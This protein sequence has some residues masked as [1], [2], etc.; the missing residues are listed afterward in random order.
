VP[1][2]FQRANTSAGD[3]AIEAFTCVLIFK[4]SLFSLIARLLAK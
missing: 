2:T 1:N 4:V 3:I